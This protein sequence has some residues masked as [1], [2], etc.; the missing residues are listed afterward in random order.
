MRFVP[1][2]GLILITIATFNIELHAQSGSKGERYALIIGIKGYPNFPEDSRLHYSD[3]D[4][5][6]F[7]E[8][9]SSIAGGEFPSRNIRLLVNADATRSTIYR[10][11]EWLG[12]RVGSK[13]LVYIF[14]AGHGVVDNSDRA[15][16]MPYDSDKNLPADKGIR[17]DQFLDEI[18][19][20]TTAKQTIVFID[21]CH[22]GAAITSGGSTR[23]ADNIVTTLRARWDEIYNV[24]APIS[25][26]IFSASSNET[27][28]EDDDLKQGLFTYFLI[29]GLKG[30]ADLNG[31][32]I[33]TAGEIRRYLTD[34][35]SAFASDK[36]HGSQTPISS[37]SFDADFPLAVFEKNSARAKGDRQASTPAPPGVVR[38]ADGGLRPASGYEWVNPS[39]SKDLTV[40]LKEGLSLTDD[41]YHLV[42]NA[43]EWI[44]PNDPKDYSVRLKTGIRKNQD[45]SFSVENNAYEWVNPSDPH[46]YSVRLK[47]GLSLTANGSYHLVN[48][49]YE[50]VNPNDP[51]DY[52][53]RLKQGLVLV[54]ENTYQLLNNAFEWVKPEDPNDFTVRLKEGLS[55]TPD[56]SYHLASNAYEWVSPSDPKDYAVKLL[57]G[58]VKTAEGFRA[59]PGYEWVNPDDKNDF[60]VRPKPQ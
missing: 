32:D 38:S 1:T 57:Q 60:R 53:V 33:V 50:W 45:G 55:L 4:A 14:F 39:D 10:E 37:A 8:F 20:K 24:R 9:I 29:K 17:A 58:L 30:E 52:S 25:M 7:Y 12:A 16:L 59:A 36:F 15:F 47:K 28:W 6:K 56:G 40:R 21:A 31:D 51:H 34:K 2:F 5:Q 26:G 19:T 54:G 22:A 18:K 46:D 27:S 43:Y 48:N 41:G 11:I 49:G 44:Y 23:S 35:V 13:D 3:L 42:N